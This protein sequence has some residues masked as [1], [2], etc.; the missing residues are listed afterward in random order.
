MYCICENISIK[1]TDY[2]YL[3][4]KQF[5]TPALLTPNV[6]ISIDQPSAVRFSN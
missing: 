3:N 4:I 6:K 1:W 2:K 5:K